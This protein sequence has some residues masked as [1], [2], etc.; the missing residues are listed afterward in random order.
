M[1]NLD[2]LI[3]VPLH[4]VNPMR[5]TTLVQV[6]VG[7]LNKRIEV[8]VPNNIQV[9]HRIR[10]KGL[11]YKGEPCGD[12]IIEISNITIE[13][14]VVQKEKCVQKMMVVN[15]DHFSEVNSCLENGWRIVDFKPFKDFDKFIN[16]YVLLEKKE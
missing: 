5:E 12:L 1:G 15:F 11:G 10:L 3:S 4:I 2:V 8:T 13:N 7:H 16:V 6:D 14:N 9:G